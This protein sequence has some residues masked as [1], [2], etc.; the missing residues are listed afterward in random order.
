M[1]LYGFAGG[2]PVNFSDPMGLCPPDSVA[3]QWF[4]AGMMGLGGLVGLVA[5]GGGGLLTGPGAIVASPFAAVSGMAIGSA[6]GLSV[7]KAISNALFSGNA[8]SRSGGKSSDE[9]DRHI[10][11]R[12]NA[13]GELGRLRDQLGQTKGPKAQQPIKD[14]IRRLEESIKGHE[15]EIR[16]KWPDGRPQ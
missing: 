9:Y 14:Q 8:Q 2:D 6:A 11:A 3:C 10:Q 13:N 1:N 12:D 5:G 7:G 15:K 4:E 16:Q